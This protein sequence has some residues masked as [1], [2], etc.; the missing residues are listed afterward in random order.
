M[1]SYGLFGRC[2]GS[3]GNR[4]LLAGPKRDRLL[5]CWDSFDNILEDAYID[6]RSSCGEFTGGDYISWLTK[7][8]A[9]SYPQLDAEASDGSPEEKLYRASMHMLLG[10][11]KFHVVKCSAADKT[12]PAVMKLYDAAKGIADVVE[13]HDPLS[14]TVYKQRV[15]AIYWTDVIKPYLDAVPDAESGAPVSENTSG[16][17]D[18]AAP[19][20][21]KGG[22][23][24]PESTR[25][26]VTASQRKS[27]AQ[28]I[29]TPGNGISGPL[30]ANDG[31]NARADASGQDST[32]GDGM[33]DAALNGLAE[34]MASDRADEQ[35][36]Q[37]MNGMVHASGVHGSGISVTREKDVTDEMMAAYEAD[38]V[39]IRNVSRDTVRMFRQKLKDRARGGVISGLYS[40]K[41]LSMQ[42]ISRNMDAV[43]QRN[44]AP[45]ML[46][47]LAVAYLGDCSGSMSGNK[48]IQSKLAASCIYEFCRELS[49]P[50][51]IFG[52]TNR[53]GVN[54]TV[55]SNFSRNR[56]D[57]YRIYGMQAK[58]CNRD[59]DAIRAVCAQLLK[60]PAD[61]HVFI[62]TSDGMPSAYGSD[63]EA[64]EDIRSAFREYRHKGVIFIAAAMDEDKDKIRALYGDSFLDISD[65]NKMPKMLV[66]KIAGY[67][68]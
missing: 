62:L 24:L 40:G 26:T 5:S 35:A 48:I 46:P 20:A 65:I 36:A 56:D 13:E 63:T 6:N 16:M 25:S 59:G 33:L 21:G 15:L 57:R 14:R 1:A 41:T 32:S 27:I 61:A 4:S 19:P 9:F 66:S 22:S 8:C 42:C 50:V 29:K 43:F 49:I 64:A 45:D 17:P 37:E 11:A 51:G 12:H 54:V 31:N 18:M 23:G 10:Y 44:T 34:R 7:K 39:T 38:S 67:L 55:Y 3:C 58:G 53:G 2:A 28:K 52:H 60:Q 30:S 47:K 68:G